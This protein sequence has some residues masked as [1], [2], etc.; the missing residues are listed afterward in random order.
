MKGCQ[1]VGNNHRKISPQHCFFWTFFSR[2]HSRQRPWRFHP[3]TADSGLFRVQ[4]CDN[5]RR[6]NVSG[7]N[8]SVRHFFDI[9]CTVSQNFQGKVPAI[10]F[11]YCIL[12]FELFDFFSRESGCNCVLSSVVA[13]S[14]WSAAM[15]LLPCSAFNA[16]RRSLKSSPCASQFF[17]YSMVH[18]SPEIKEKRTLSQKFDS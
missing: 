2:E 3:R 12:P 1:E 7:S 13:G 17:S 4:T 16:A 14:P 6:R 15:P 10:R 5:C 9:F 18:P 8:V 11:S